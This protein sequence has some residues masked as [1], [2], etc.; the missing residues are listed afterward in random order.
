MCT[1]FNESIK[2]VIE[3]TKSMLYST[4]GIF[5]KYEFLGIVIL[6]VAAII[7]HAVLENNDKS[8]KIKKISSIIYIIIMLHL[9]K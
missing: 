9:K 6:V 2:K 7:V 8:N 3:G 1:Y 5:P 4:F